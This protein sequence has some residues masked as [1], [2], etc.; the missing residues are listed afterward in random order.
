MATRDDQMTRAFDPMEIQREN[1]RAELREELRHA[2]AMLPIAQ[3][4]M[5]VP[6]YAAHWE[7]R[8]AELTAQLM[9]L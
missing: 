7:Q 3:E 5:Q 9:A 4:N 8:I 1:K 2:T 6:E